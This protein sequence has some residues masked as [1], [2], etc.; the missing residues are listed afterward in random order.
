MKIAFRVAYSIFDKIAY[1][2]N[3]YWAL[4]IP[5]RDV[6]FNR[7][8]YFNKALNPKIDKLENPCLRALYWLSK[9][10]KDKGSTEDLILG[11]VMEP[12]ASNLI[13]LR[14]HLEHKYA[15]IHDDFYKPLNE[16]SDSLF[17]DELAYYIS[18]S[19][20]CNKSIRLMRLSRAAI[21]YLT[22]AVHHEERLKSSK[23]KGLT[24]AMPIHRV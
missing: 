17:K 20:F 15:K 1:F 21:I 23:L 6:N 18:F 8:W 13:A 4:E 12:D 2:I 7:V 3:D 11:Q 16:V 22:L 19:E 10:F 24:A 14:N 9:D 5:E